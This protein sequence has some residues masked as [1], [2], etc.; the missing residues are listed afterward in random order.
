MTR[1]PK[2]APRRKVVRALGQLGFEVVRE[3]NHIAIAEK[4]RRRERHTVDD[5]QPYEST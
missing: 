3:G 4:K 5:A 1:F 2:D